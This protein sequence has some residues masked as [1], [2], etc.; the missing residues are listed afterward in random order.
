M[1]ISRWCGRSLIIIREQLWVFRVGEP[2]WYLFMLRYS[3]TQLIME[4]TAEGLSTISEV[5]INSCLFRNRNSMILIS[6]EST[7]EAS[8]ASCTICKCS[9]SWQVCFLQRFAQTSLQNLLDTVL[10]F[11]LASVFL[12]CLWVSYANH[13]NERRQRSVSDFLFSHHS[14]KLKNSFV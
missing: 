8:I 6:A 5:T 10:I 11:F 9:M 4:I 1:E 7:V 13:T 2:S 3:V 14:T 12:L